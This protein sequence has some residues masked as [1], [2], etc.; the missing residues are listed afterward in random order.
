MTGRTRAVP[1]LRHRGEGDGCVAS[2]ARHRA[3]R[4]LPVFRRELEGVA[5]RAV[6]SIRAGMDRRRVVL[7]RWWRLVGVARRAVPGRGHAV[8]V[9]HGTRGAHASRRHRC[10]P[11]VDRSEVTGVTTA[12]S[13]TTRIPRNGRVRRVDVLVHRGRGGGGVASGLSARRPVPPRRQL[14]DERRM[15]LAATRV[16]R[17][18]RLGVLDAQLDGVAGRARDPRICGRAD[19]EVLRRRVAGVG[20][21]VVVAGDLV[22]VAD[23]AVLRGRDATGVTDHAAGALHTRNRRRRIRVDRG[24]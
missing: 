18:G 8:S 6:W 2:D 9:A 15:A 4:C 20:G 7:R 14:P 5:V 23:G 10:G 21:C 17:R 11:R 1:R 13:R 19:R 3:G 24:E 16:P 22:G 12:S